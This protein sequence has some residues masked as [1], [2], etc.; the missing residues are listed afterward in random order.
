[1]KNTTTFSTTG[2]SYWHF[3]LIGVGI[4]YNYNIKSMQVFS[5]CEHTGQLMKVQ[6]YYQEGGLSQERFKSLCE[7]AYKKLINEGVTVNID[8]M[9]DPTIVGCI[10]VDFDLIKN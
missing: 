4:I 1:M 7:D 9:D 10:G 5:T 2:N 8:F 3:H 6:E